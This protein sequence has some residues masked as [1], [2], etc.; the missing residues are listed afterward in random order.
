MGVS[1][2]WAFSP[3][4][5]GARRTRPAWNGPARTNL[6]PVQEVDAAIKRVDA[7][8][9][10]AQEETAQMTGGDYNRNIKLHMTEAK[11]KREVDEIGKAQ[12]AGE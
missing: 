10:T 7:G 1:T 8:F 3:T 11:R 9:S 2:R 6:N 12:T 5:R 4:R